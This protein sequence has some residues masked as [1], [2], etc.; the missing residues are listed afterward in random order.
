MNGAT[1]QSNI[2]PDHPEKRRIED[3]LREAAADLPESWKIT[4]SPLGWRGWAVWIT[5]YPVFRAILLRPVQQNAKSVR[6]R[7]K[8]VLPAR[9]RPKGIGA[10]AESLRKS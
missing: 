10:R 5:G 8:S 1:V 6:L 2:P 7:L 9:A 4:I 3:M